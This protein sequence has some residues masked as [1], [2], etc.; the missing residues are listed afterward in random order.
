MLNLCLK[1]LKLPSLLQSIAFG[2]SCDLVLVNV[3]VLRNTLCR[4]QE[5]HTFN[6]SQKTRRAHFKTQSE[7]KRCTFLT[8]AWPK[9]KVEEAK[10]PDK[11]QELLPE[12]SHRVL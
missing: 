5:V 4:R 11:A 2:D 3:I 12:I 7:D 8:P 1:N 6:S 9:A 10:Q